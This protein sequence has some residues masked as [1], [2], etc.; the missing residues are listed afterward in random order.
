MLTNYANPL[1]GVP[2]VESPFFN[3][4][5]D[6]GH[7]HYQ[8]ATDL[9]HNGYA[10]FDF[11]DDEIG[12]VAE[13]IKRDLHPHYNWDGWRRG[14]ADMRIQ[15]AWQSNADVRRLATNAK[16][17]EIL[18][19]LYGRPAFPFQTLNFATGTQQHFHTDSVH[20]SSMPE[21]FMCGVWLAL[22]DIGMDQGPLIYYP[23]SHR[24]PIYTNE[25]IGHTFRG[26][27]HQAVFEP[28]WER[29]VDVM[30]VKPE[31][32]TVKRGQAL[33]WAA[34]LLH[35]GDHHA[36]HELSRWSQVTHYFFED[37][38]YYTPLRSNEP[39][40]E[41]LFRRPFDIVTGAERDCYYNGE[42]LPESVKRGEVRLAD[43]EA[44]P[45]VRLPA[46][47]DGEAYRRLNPDVAMT[48]IDPAE[49][50]LIYGWREDRR[51]A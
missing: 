34:N 41:I 3:E 43:P 36:D 47:F 25:H 24:W 31:R 21:R 15:D 40:N 11:P 42:P 18:S 8:I 49:H 4:L 6:P 7:E 48:G 13:R 35:G 20:F 26:G 39:R 22:E 27:G 32:F 5:F 45:A 29:L 12:D 14:N 23:G 28:M 10:V 46:D 30:G 33:I 37:C 44:D 16:V 51:W 38:A 9:H 17:L 2:N 1:P 50:Y 19:S